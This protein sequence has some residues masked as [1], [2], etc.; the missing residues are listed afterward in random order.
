LQLKMILLTEFY[1][2]ITLNV[3]ENINIYYLKG[4]MYILYVK[5]A[6]SFHDFWASCIFLGV[7]MDFQLAT[8]F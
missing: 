4:S 6:I 5:S 2:P 8:S 1:N 3:R 7:G